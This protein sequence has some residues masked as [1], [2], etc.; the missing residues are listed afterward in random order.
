M[1]RLK[2]DDQMVAMRMKEPYLDITHPWDLL[3]AN[4]VLMKDIRK[5]VGKGQLEEGVVI[6]GTLH[7]GEGTI[8]K[9][10]TYIEGNVII[11]KDSKIGPGSY[12]RGSTYI[13]DRCHIGANVELKNSIIMDDSN[14][15]HHNYIGDSILGRRCN[16]GSGTKVANLRLDNKNITSFVKRKAVNTGRRKLGVIMGDDVK[17]GIN[18]CLNVGTVIGEGTLIGPGAVVTGWIEPKSQVL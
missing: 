2:G 5:K 10:G 12:I 6:H 14:V 11:G 7:L 8:L 16:L 13:G 1:L 17:T 3:T 18:S 9:A 15:P 4:E